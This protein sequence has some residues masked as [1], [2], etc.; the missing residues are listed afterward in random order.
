LQAQFGVSDLLAVDVRT[1]RAPHITNTA[2]PTVAHYL[3]VIKRYSRTLLPLN[4]N[5]VVR[6]APDSLHTFLQ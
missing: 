2:Q 4:D 6:R 1:I 5:V 3:E